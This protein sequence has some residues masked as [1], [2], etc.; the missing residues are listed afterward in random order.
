MVSQLEWG[1]VLNKPEKFE[2]ATF[3][4]RFKFAFKENLANI[5]VTASFSKS[6]VFIMASVHMKT[7]CW[8]FQIPSVGRSFL[9]SRVFVTG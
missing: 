8:R 7:K 6:T 5:V 1:S 9:K 2:N 4:G 3:T